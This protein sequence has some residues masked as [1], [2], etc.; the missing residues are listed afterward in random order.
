MTKARGYTQK[1]H[2]IEEGI[3]EGKIKMFVFLILD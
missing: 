2:L 3:S 1:E